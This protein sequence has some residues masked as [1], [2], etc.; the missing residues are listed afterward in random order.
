[1]LLGIQMSFSTDASTRAT[2]IWDNICWKL[3]FETGEL[4]LSGE[5]DT[6]RLPALTVTNRYEHIPWYAY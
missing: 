2:G 1:M 5:G 6:P 4:I 3:D